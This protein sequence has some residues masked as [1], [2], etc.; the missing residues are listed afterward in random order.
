MILIENVIFISCNTEF[1]Y[2]KETEPNISASYGLDD[3]VFGVRFPVGSR[4]FTPPYRPDGSRA[5]LVPGALSS[6]VK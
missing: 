2:V 6:R 5:R 1:H 3:Q 4:M